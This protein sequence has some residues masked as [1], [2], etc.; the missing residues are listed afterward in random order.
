MS[1]EGDSTLSPI[2][3][4]ADVRLYRRDADYSRP[5]L[6]VPAESARGLTEK[7]RVLYGDRA[8][9]CYSELERIMQVHYAFKTPEII[10]AEASFQ[11]QDRFSEKDIV[12]ITYA[13]QLQKRGTPPLAFLAEMLRIFLHGV[14][15]TVHLL[16]F[17]PYSSDRGFSVIDYKVV[18]PRLGSWDEI[19]SLHRGFKLMFDG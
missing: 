12:G 17:Y 10:A 6:E 2:L 15:N 1:G 14:I 18:D 19:E 9:A 4:R 3:A 16:P 8:D 13:D 11:P 7:L 5:L